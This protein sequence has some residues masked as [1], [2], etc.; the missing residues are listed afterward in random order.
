M[1]RPRHYG[2]SDHAETQEWLDAFASVVEHSSPERARQL[3]QWL[4]AD[5]A[6]L[7]VA[8]DR[9]STPYVNTIAREQEPMMPGDP[10]LE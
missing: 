10:N 7:G 9:L 5:A 2:D 6:R 8:I 4:N 3:L 1:A